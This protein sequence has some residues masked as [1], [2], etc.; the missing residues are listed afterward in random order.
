MSRKHYT[1]VFTQ[2]DR[3]NQWLAHVKERPEC[4]T[5][6]RGLAQTRAR[7]R[8]ALIL[9][10]GDDAGDAD[11]TEQLPLPAT[12]EAVKRRLDDL[13]AEW[14]QILEERDE[15]IAAMQDADWSLR[16]IAEFFGLSHQRIAQVVGRPRRQR[17]TTARRQRQVG[18][19]QGRRG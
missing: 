15:A 9:W 13:T 10:E 19:G 5:F 12:A 11:I 1:L 4:H 3:Q 6:G 16:D 7:I 18:A 17:R 14:E 8:E 2:G